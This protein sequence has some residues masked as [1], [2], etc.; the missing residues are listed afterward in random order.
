[1]QKR[2]KDKQQ[3]ETPDIPNSLPLSVAKARLSRAESI[4]ASEQRSQSRSSSTD[5]GKSRSRPS[6]HSGTPAPPDEKD[7]TGS[8][9]PAKRSHKRRLKP[10]LDSAQETGGS[11][12]AKKKAL[13]RTEVRTTLEYCGMDLPH[14]M[15][16][17]DSLDSLGVLCNHSEGLARREND[18]M[19]TG[20]LCLV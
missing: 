20:T 12:K 5:R 2:S 10:E 4:T 14:G 16:S 7:T 9:A 18:F 13:E 11:K 19:I 8:S 1:M 3:V 6:S 15:D 17:R